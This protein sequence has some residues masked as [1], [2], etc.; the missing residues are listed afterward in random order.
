MFLN[1][2]DLDLHRNLAKQP[3]DLS[4]MQKTHSKGRPTDSTT[5]HSKYGEPVT[6]EMSKL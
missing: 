2:I 1:I 3:S 6:D 4:N 5:H